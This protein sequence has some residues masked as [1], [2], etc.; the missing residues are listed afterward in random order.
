MDCVSSPSLKG[1]L[2]AATQKMIILT[3]FFAEYS[4]EYHFLDLQRIEKRPLEDY[5]V[6][7][8]PNPSL[9]FQH[10]GLLIKKSYLSKHHLSSTSAFSK[11]GIVCNCVKESA[12]YYQNN[13]YT[14][15]KM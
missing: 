3:I 6:V 14:L 7:P 13:E 4:I 15:K 12:D 2:R 11:L 10:A 9:M 1:R 5:T 8:Y